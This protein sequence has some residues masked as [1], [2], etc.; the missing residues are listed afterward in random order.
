MAQS[1]RITEPWP[2]SSGRAGC[3]PP[4]VQPPAWSPSIAARISSLRSGMRW[5]A[6]RG[7]PRR[8]R[9]RLPRGPARRAARPASASPISRAAACWARPS[10]RTR[11]TGRRGSPAAGPRAAIFL[12]FQRDPRQ[13]V[14]EVPRTAGYF[15]VRGEGF[16][17]L[18]RRVMVGEVV[19]QF[20]DP[21]R[22]FRRSCPCLRNR[23]TL[24]YDAVSTSIEKGHRLL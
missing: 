14:F 3:L 13:P 23:L 17:V 22:V 11:P 12:A 9:P 10:S 2:G 5:K 24:E 4:L 8:R 1:H 6:A 16:A 7:L 20:L 19:D 21:H 18:R 15:H